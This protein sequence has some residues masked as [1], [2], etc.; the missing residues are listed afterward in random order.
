MYR[1]TIKS[2]PLKEQNLLSG[3]SCRWNIVYF[4]SITKSKIE[5]KKNGL[6]IADH[7]Q[8]IVGKHLLRQGGGLYPRGSQR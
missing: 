2:L 5:T 7:V 3:L 6:H 8:P 1:P 4:F